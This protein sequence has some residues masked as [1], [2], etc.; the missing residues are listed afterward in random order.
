MFKV[1]KK[2]MFLRFY[3]DFFKFSEKAFCV[4]VKKLPKYVN[5]K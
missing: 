4:N 1:K 2:F 5:K 3:M